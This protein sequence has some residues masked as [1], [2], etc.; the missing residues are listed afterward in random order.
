MD[1]RV[2]LEAAVQV[3]DVT[4]RSEAVRI[5]VAKTGEMLNPDLSHVE[6]AAPDRERPD[7]GRRPPAFVAAGE[8]LVALELEML[9][10]D[11]EGPKHAARV[12]RKE[13]GG[14]LDGVPLEV[15]SVEPAPEADQ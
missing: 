4:D 12:A 2:V 1:R 15:S 6:I 8:A 10:F 3:Y 14:H 5:A 13:V 11:T 9:V 7:G